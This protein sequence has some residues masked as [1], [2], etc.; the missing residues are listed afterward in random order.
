MEIAALEVGLCP[1]TAMSSE[2]PTMPLTL[3]RTKGGKA[4]RVY[5]PTP[6]I[7]RTV[8]YIREERVYVAKRTGSTSNALFLTNRGSAL[9]KESITASFARACE[10]A[11][12]EA[13]FHELRHTFAVMM[14]RAL[15]R[16]T[17]AHPQMNPLQLLKVLM[18]HASVRTTEVYLEV[19]LDELMA[20]EDAIAAEVAFA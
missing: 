19:L 10:Q 1:S 18:G 12:I 8:A 14:L 3:T 7:N 2:H 15:Q 9:S 17:A 11:S 13:H 6:L 20:V 4:R 5:V 16:Q